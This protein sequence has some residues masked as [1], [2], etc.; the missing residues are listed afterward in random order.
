MAQGVQETYEARVAAG[1]IVP[2]PFQRAVVGQLDALAR[3]LGGPSP[4]RRFGLFRAPT[5]PPPRGMYIWGHVG[6]GK[7]M[8]MDMFVAAAATDRKRRVHFHAFMQE[9][10]RGLHAARQTLVEDALEPVAARLVRDTRLLCLDEMQITDI[11]DA[12]I[13]GRLFEALLDAGVVVVTTS[14]RPPEDLYKDGLNRQ[15]FLPFIDLIRVRLDVVELDGPEDYRQSA[16]RAEQRYFSPPDARARAALDA[17]W[18]RAAGGDGEPCDLTVQGRQVRLPA[19]RNRVARARFWDLCARPLGPADYLA[20]AEAVDVLILEDIPELS[21][22]NYNEARRF[23]TLID[24]LYE[25]RV[26]LYAS[27][28][29]PAHRLYLEGAGAFEFERTASRIAEMQGADWG[30]TDADD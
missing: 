20:M 4:Q 13:V 2:D 6:R 9:V 23:V 26:V 19:V 14:N 25:A 5:A 27:A 28:A 11:T 16:E 7:S 17:V 29:A 22:E 30:R 21:S 1:V 3:G 10:H 12:M 8:L 18:A 15:L 24:A